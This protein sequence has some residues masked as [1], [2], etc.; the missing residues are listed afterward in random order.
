MVATY[1]F[2]VFYAVALLALTSLGLAVIFGMMQ[3]INLAH[4]EFMMLGAYTCVLCYNAGL[5]YVLSLVVAMVVVG[6]FGVIVERLII[7]RLY[8]QV[9]DTLLVTWGLSLLMIG[10]VTAIFG[11]QAKSM[12][13]SFGSLEIAGSRFSAY[14]FWLIA[15][16]VL[17]MLVTWALARFTTAGLIVRG[18]IQAPDTC[19]ALGVNTHFVYM[20]TFAYGSAMAGLA[21]G[22]LAP[23]T[24]A[25][26]L[27]GASFVAKAFIN[28]IVGGRLPLLGTALAS[29]MFGTIDGTVS[30]ISSSIAGEITVLACAVVLLRLLPTGI[31]GRFKRGI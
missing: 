2:L 12:Q 31:T 19:R 28:V 5:P 25:S 26:P 23:L 24:G 18:T 27:M 10:V 22:V 21:G 29:A 7:R 20:G 8:G 15:I 4:G 3:V 17:M 11:P 13:L 1:F 6:L 16:A 30:F 9:V 14:S